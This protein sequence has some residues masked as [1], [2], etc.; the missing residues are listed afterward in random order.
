MKPRTSIKSGPGTTE[1]PYCGRRL[2]TQ[3]Y[4]LF[5]R[6]VEVPMLCDCEQAVAEQEREERERRESERREA[7]LKVWLR[8]GV[9]EE[10]L[11]VPAEPAHWDTL[12]H[13]GAL[14]ITGPNGRG[15]TWLACQCA[16]HYLVRH[17]YEDMGV[18]K[19]RKS[20]RFITAQQVMSSI[21]STYGRWTASEEDVYQRL[22]GVDLLLLDDLGKG[23]PTPSSAEA[24]FRVASER[25]SGRRATIFT[26]Q[27]DTE[28]LAERFASADSETVDAML[29]RLRGR[30]CEGVRLDGPDRRLE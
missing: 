10:Y 9:P 23:S 5:G 22:V 3:R 15:K 28:G 20:F 13:G 12:N 27:Y 29:S 4:P 1:C 30:W 19:C 7:F 17:T 24:F 25:C 6:W 16:R 8:S 2:G 26:S 21:R 18:T 11:R 14:Y